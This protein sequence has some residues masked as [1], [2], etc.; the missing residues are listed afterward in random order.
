MADVRIPN[1][2]QPKPPPMIMQKHGNNKTL[3]HRKHPSNPT[4]DQQPLI[5]NVAKSCSHKTKF[6]RIMEIIPGNEMNVLKKIFRK[7]VFGLG[8]PK[9]VQILYIFPYTISHRRSVLL[10]ET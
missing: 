9:D 1:L 6:P 2:P 3:R 7:C 10:L 5:C 8:A 4:S